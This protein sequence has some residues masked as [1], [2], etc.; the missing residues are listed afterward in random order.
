MRPRRRKIRPRT[1]TPD[2]SSSLEYDGEIPE[3]ATLA[4]LP[5]ISDTHEALRK[6][7]GLAAEADVDQ[8]WTDAL[9]PRPRVWPSVQEFLRRQ[10]PDL[11][12]LYRRVLFD[13]AYRAHYVD[14]L[15]SRIDQAAADAGPGRQGCRAPKA[16]P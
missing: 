7:F 10:R 13:S 3:P 4:L 14:E 2:C 6:L 12:E 9:N 15:H 5:A 1:R 8:I 11:L 16:S